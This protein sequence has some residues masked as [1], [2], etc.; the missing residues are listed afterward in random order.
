MPGLIT[1]EMKLKDIFPALAEA[2]QK[3]YSLTE[4]PVFIRKGL[5][6][7]DL[8]FDEGE[9][10]SIDYITTIDKDRDNEI[11]DPAGCI[12]TDYMKNPVVLFGHNHYGMPVGKCAWIKADMKGLVAKT[13]Y[14]NTAQANEIYEYRKAG[15]PMAKSIGF[16][17]LEAV[18]YSEGTPEYAQGVY[19]KFTRWLLLEYSDVPVPSNPEALEIAVSKGLLKPEEAGEYTILIEEEKTLETAAE[20][21]FEEEEQKL[22]NG[23]GIEQ[24][25]GII[26]AE[27]KQ[28]DISG[29]PS[30]WDIYRAINALFET[31]IGNRNI[32]VCDLY[33]VNFPNGHCIL[34]IESSEGDKY[35]QYE[36]TF[37]DGKAT[38]GAE[39]IEIESGYKPKK[40]FMYGGKELVIPEEKSGR[41][42]SAKNRTIIE[43]A[44]SALKDLLAATEPAEEEPEDEE[45]EGKSINE[46]SGEAENGSELYIFQVDEKNE[47]FED[48]I[49]IEEVKRF[50]A[51]GF[52]IDDIAPLIKSGIATAL[53]ERLIPA[54]KE[55]ARDAVNIKRGRLN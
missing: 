40:S 25:V 38:L 27:E 34:N 31:P 11:V 21:L 17:P 20:V 51:G 18:R 7:S 36:Y 54:I 52:T 41:I 26:G 14:A 8:K 46:L 16:I 1:Q 24:P 30:V 35:Y 37:V 55:A 43:T 53:D 28:A 3:D 50:D 48:S 2:V 39:Y 6:P 44:V 33:P 9:R 15:F 47:S 23:D 22:I 10:S 42:L 32:W 13:I 29:N 5:I 12:L 49:L 19:R 45:D 4:E